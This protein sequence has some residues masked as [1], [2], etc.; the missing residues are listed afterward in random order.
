MNLVQKSQDTKSTVVIN[1]TFRY[2]FFYAY[3]PVIAI[4]D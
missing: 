4:I 2:I 1:Y 3:L